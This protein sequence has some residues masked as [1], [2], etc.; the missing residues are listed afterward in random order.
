MLGLVSPT[1]LCAK[2]AMKVWFPGIALGSMD[3]TIKLYQHLRIEYVALRT[4][5]KI[6]SH[7]LFDS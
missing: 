5:I 1:L 4:F 2:P 6:R 3:A 7:S